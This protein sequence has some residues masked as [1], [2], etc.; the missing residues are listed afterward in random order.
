MAE[1]AD[2]LPAAWHCD[3]LI[4]RRGELRAGER[5][6]ELRRWNA[7]GW[8]GAGH[9]AATSH[10]LVFELRH[11]RAKEVLMDALQDV[12]FVAS[13]HPAVRGYESG[14]SMRGSFRIDRNPYPPPPAP[15]DAPPD[16][17]P[18]RNRWTDRNPNPPPP[19]PPDDPD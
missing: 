19:A 10:D 1:P 12:R 15:P 6:S 3:E 13:H 4:R 7:C 14:I 16:A 18:P 8:P 17:L 5:V 9:G 2:E 11:F